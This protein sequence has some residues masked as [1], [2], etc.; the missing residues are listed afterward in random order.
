L[1]DSGRLINESPYCLLK[2][3][4][5]LTVF[6]PQVDSWLIGTVNMISPDHIGIIVYSLFNASI[7][8]SDLKS[9]WTQSG[10]T[11]ISQKNTRIS[12]GS[13]VKFKVKE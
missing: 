12:V 11:W 2:I 7:A 1:E 3:K 9:K 5:D 13:L 10:D 8:S 4:A 6:A